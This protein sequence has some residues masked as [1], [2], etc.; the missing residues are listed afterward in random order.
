MVV[1]DP[2]EWADKFRSVNIRFLHCVNTVWFNCI[3]NLP[4]QP[5]ED[6]ITINLVDNLLKNHEARKL[7]YWL[8]YQFEP[9]GYTPEGEVYSKGKIDMALLL[10][11]ERE[12]YI[13]YECKRLNINYKDKT[14]SLA[15]PYV[16]EGLTRFVDE[17]YAA[18]LP[19]GCML[20]Y[21]IDGNTTNAKSKIYSAIN[22]NK[23]DIK[24]KVKPSS[25][26]SIGR[27][28]RFSSRHI[29][30]ICNLEIEILHALVPF[31]N[32]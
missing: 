9:F 5:Y 14:L 4:G 30:T 3:S 1:G 18:T 16:K 10:D 28:K 17:K 23:S 12:L 6:A 25:L 15:T 21:V 31:S 13:A 29:R 20:G 2:T 11:R 19:V 32:H 8:E 24:L 22:E 27:M 7:F 26:P